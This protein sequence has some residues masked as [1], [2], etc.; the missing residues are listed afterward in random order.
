[1]NALQQILLGRVQWTD[2]NGNPLVGGKVYSYVPGTTTFQNT[3]ADPAGQT[4][5]E[6]PITLDARGEAT[7][8]GIG[9]YRQVVYDSAGDLIWDVVTGTAANGASVGLVLSSI[10]SLRQLSHWLSG[11]VFVT[12]YY[13]AHDGGGG[14]Y[15]YDPNDT[16][17]IDNGGTVIVAADGGRWK[18]QAI[19]PISVK[20][21]GAHGDNTTDDSGF[22]QTWINYL[23]SSGR[24]GYI[25]ASQYLIG[26]QL[27]VDL[28]TASPD[29][30]K[31]FGDG[32][33]T[34][35]LN[36]QSVSVSPA[37]LI[38]GKP[39]SQGAG[40]YSSFAD[41]AIHGNITG[42]L[43]QLGPD[44]N[45]AAL[46]AIEFRNLWVGNN[47]TSS[48]AI[49]IQVNYVLGTKFD[50]VVA[51]NNHAGDS[52]QI[53]AAAFCT[54]IGGAATWG[55]NGMHLTYNRSLFGTIAGNVFIGIDFEENVGC[56]IKIDSAN[57]HDNT[58]TGGTHV[59]V[60]GTTY[61]CD[62]TQG[63]NNRI[64]HPSINAGASASF[65]NFFNNKVGMAVYGVFGI[66]WNN[67]PGNPAF[68]SYMSVGQNPA[69][70]TW[71]KV[72][73]NSIDF[74][75]GNSYDPTT[76]YRYT[77]QTPG[78]H[79]FSVIVQ[80]TAT[81][82]SLATHQLALYRNGTALRTCI[83]NVAAGSNTI[84]LQLLVQCSLSVGDY[85]EAWVN[86]ASSSGSPAIGGGNA[87]SYFSGALRNI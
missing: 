34:S 51:A 68:N 25:P 61:A 30:V 73:F 14:A 39:D 11:A 53:C 12:G 71:T 63:Q 65:A 86:L 50:N 38:T 19:G 7:M 84:T 9:S 72:A 55:V 54:W 70:G 44:D 29:G 33:Q 59:Y 27:K 23:L 8:W 64:E 13:S 24:G 56:N 37:F 15:Q 36:M 48:N 28:S 82:A 40:F 35:M 6:N 75:N 60:P 21:F 47:S 79:E 4:L 77:C 81:N 20:Q 1:M 31:I 10:A 74:Q 58:W 45:S 32:Q 5:N 78:V 41:F 18:L 85:I 52:W 43:L 80:V 83:Q 57:A 62:A 69:A 2:G 3:Y 46:N 66:T 42:T 87:S 67:G 26:A 22:F 17:S 49:G 16:T 76:N